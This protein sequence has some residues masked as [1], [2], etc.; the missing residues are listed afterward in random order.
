MQSST[1]MGRQAKFEDTMFWDIVLYGSCF[2]R[3]D[4]N[5]DAVMQGRTQRAAFGWLSS[6]WKPLRHGHQ[7]GRSPTW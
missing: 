1:T 3:S 6:Q 2:A 5:G 4:N 7:P